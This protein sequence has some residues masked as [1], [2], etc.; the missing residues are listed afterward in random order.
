MLEFPAGTKVTMIIIEIYV[1]LEYAFLE[2]V[3][4]S[5]AVALYHAFLLCSLAVPVSL[6][7]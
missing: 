4:L 2:L 6:R 3:L 5:T 7:L 1:F